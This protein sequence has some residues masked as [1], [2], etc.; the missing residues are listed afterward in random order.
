M[1]IYLYF[2]TFFVFPKYKNVT[3]YFLEPLITFFLITV[4][5]CLS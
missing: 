1:K 5:G 3:L 4:W 2:V